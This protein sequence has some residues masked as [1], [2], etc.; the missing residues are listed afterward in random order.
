VF[1]ERIQ[2]IAPAL[3]IMPEKDAKLVIG[4]VQLVVGHQSAA[5]LNVDVVSTIGPAEAAGVVPTLEIYPFYQPL[6][7]GNAYL[8]MTAFSVFLGH[9]GSMAGIDWAIDGAT[10]VGQ[11]IYHLSIPVGF[12]RKIRVRAQAIQPPE[13]RLPPSNAAWPCSTCCGTGRCGLVAQVG[14]MAPGLLAGVFVIGRRRRRKQAPP[15]A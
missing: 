9:D 1:L 8:P 4:L 2:R 12:A 11:N 6:G 7:Q 10:K 15:A 3:Q 13:A 5:D 14:N